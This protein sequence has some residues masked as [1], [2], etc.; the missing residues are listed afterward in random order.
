MLPKG[1]N[2]QVMSDLIGFTSFTGSLDITS[3]VP[4]V[5]LSLNFEAAAVFSSLPP[6][7][8]DEPAPAHP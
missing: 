4:I 2:A 7:E 6:G 8:V 3:T 5:S 1:H